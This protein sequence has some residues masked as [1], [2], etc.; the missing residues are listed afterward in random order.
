CD[1][2]AAECPVTP[3]YAFVEGNF[4]GDKKASAQS[5]QGV[6]GKKVAAEVRLPRKVVERH[7]HTTPEKMVDYWRMSA[8]GGVMSG[9]IGVQGLY[10]NGLA[11]LFIACGQD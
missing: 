5:F 4:S 10:V 7:L 11:A 1:Y 3:D 6:R 9:T 8:L 2:I